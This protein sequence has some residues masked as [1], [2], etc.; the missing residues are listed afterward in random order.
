MSR[1]DRAC[2]HWRLVS[3]GTRSCGDIIA[4]LVSSNV[5]LARPV[6]PSS[7]FTLWL[8]SDRST[9][10]SLASLTVVPSSCSRISKSSTV[11]SPTLVSHTRRPSEALHAVMRCP[12]AL[13][14][15]S[16][17]LPDRRWPF[18]RASE[19]KCC[20]H[21]SAPSLGLIAPTVLFCDIEYRSEALEPAYGLWKKVASCCGRPN[22]A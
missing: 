16:C 14:T 8:L 13:I 21:T 19:G 12:T 17:P 11:A 20:R 6:F 7:L 1:L 4:Y 5:H 3:S 10:A 2:P 9:M 18:E 15:V 22:R